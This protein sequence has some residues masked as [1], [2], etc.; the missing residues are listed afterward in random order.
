VTGRVLHDDLAAAPT[1]A[2]PAAPA[3]PALEEALGHCFR[4]LNRAER[5]VAQVRHHLER[6]RVRP[7]VIDAALA[8]L[9]R[10]GWLDDV[11][12]AQRFTHA[13]RALDGWGR[14]RI[15]RALLAAGVD[16]DCV[17]DAIGPPAAVRELEAAITLLQRRFRIAPQT[18]RDRA[19]ALGLL[20]RKG[21][22]RELAYDA[23]R[24]FG[25]Q[26]SADCT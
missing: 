17:A 3:D 15:G 7:E 25:R 24:E 16:P 1:A 22:Q 9:E 12:Y 21:Y 19:R 6:R 10:E 8:Q 26:A 4:L 5:T 14:E 20:L 2:V 23:V 11:K 18:D 13:R